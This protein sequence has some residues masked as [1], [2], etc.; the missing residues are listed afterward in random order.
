[1][2]RA[3]APAHILKKS[4]KAFAPAL[5]YRDPPAT[6]SVIIWVLGVVAPRAHCV[7]AV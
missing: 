4:R 5:T 7:E 6:V 3:W 1:M 2:A